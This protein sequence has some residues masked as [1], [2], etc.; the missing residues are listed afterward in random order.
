VFRIALLVVR[1]RE[2]TVQARPGQG[3]LLAVAAA[4]SSVVMTQSSAAV[5]GAGRPAPA[6]LVS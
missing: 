3:A 1:L 2:L 6:A 4:L 5:Q